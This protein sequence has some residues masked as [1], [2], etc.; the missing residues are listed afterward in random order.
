MIRLTARSLQ[1]DIKSED[2]WLDSDQIIN[3]QSIFHQSVSNVI[4]PVEWN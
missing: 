1:A 2:G 4:L 3:S